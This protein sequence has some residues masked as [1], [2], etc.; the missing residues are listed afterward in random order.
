MNFCPFLGKIELF[1]LI[2]PLQRTCFKIVYLL[3][4]W[5]SVVILFNRQTNNMLVFFFYVIVNN[6]C[7]NLLIQQWLQNSVHVTAESIYHIQ[8]GDRVFLASLH[9][10][11]ARWI[12]K[13]SL[14]RSISASGNTLRFDCVVNIISNNKN[15]IDVSGNC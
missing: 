8:S 7:I 2:V 9:E 15:Y 3:I 4:S 10:N 5:R 1:T 12:S 14:V 11:D 13:V 6:S